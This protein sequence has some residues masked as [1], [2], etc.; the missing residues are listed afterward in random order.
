MANL[1]ARGLAKK[2]VEQGNELAQTVG[3]PFKREIIHD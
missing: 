3:K 1:I 2:A